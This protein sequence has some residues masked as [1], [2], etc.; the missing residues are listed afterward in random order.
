M[1]LLSLILGVPVSL[2][3]SIAIILFVYKSTAEAQRA[4]ADMIQS[5]GGLMVNLPSVLIYLS[6]LIPAI[7]FAY[8]IMQFSHAGAHRV[9]QTTIVRSMQTLRLANRNSLVAQKML[10]SGYSVLEP[11][12]IIPNAKTHL[13]DRYAVGDDSIRGDSSQ[14]GG[15][16][17]SHGQDALWHRNQSARD[18]SVSTLPISHIPE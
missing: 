12:V 3:G 1:K 9:R 10:Q 7:A 4:T 18:N 17:S 8:M 2:A 16:E 15:A 5:V 6:L 13:N 11:E 14:R